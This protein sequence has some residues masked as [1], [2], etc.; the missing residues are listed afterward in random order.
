MHPRLSVGDEVLA[1]NMLM[2]SPLLVTTLL[3]N[4]ETKLLARKPLPWRHS[5]P[6]AYHNGHIIA[7]LAHVR[8]ANVP[9]KGTRAD[10]QTHEAR[11]RV[12]HLNEKKKTDLPVTGLRQA[13]P[14]R[15]TGKEI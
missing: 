15:G 11:D 6:L 7:K 14:A 5:P 13:C 10:T 8:T 9:S 4:V 2:T 1:L 3:T 12:S